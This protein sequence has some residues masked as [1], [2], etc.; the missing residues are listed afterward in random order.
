MIRLLVRALIYFGSAAVGIATAA[1]VLDDV[2]VEPTGFVAVVVV[3]AV[4]QTVLTPFITRVAL[5]N[6]TALLGGTGLVAAFLALLV[7]AALGDALSITGGIGSW[8]AAT[9]V[10]WLSTALATLVLPLLLVKAGVESARGTHQE[11]P[12]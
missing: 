7:A 5:K 9:V 3:Y 2:H 8:L 12:A 6:A 4:L 11:E 10:V 1:L